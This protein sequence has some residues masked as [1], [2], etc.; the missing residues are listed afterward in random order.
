MFRVVD[1]TA[2]A[3]REALV[4]QWRAIATA[5]P[6]LDLAA[7]SRIKGWRNREVVAHLALQPALL[8]RFLESASTDVP[9]LSL[10]ANLAG[11]VR[12]AELIDA[13]ARDASDAD[14]DFGGRL[15]RALPIL[16]GADLAVT[17]TTLQ[18]RIAL[19][20]YLRTRCIEAVVHGCDLNP[21]VTPDPE[22]LQVAADALL[23]ALRARR[24]G[25]VP[26]ARTLP[27]L[28]WVDQATGRA[29]ASERLDGVLPVMS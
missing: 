26:A 18:G 25:L 20:D 8:A 27:L 10:T 3:V 16:S 19:V 12:L 28:E 13:S 1:G 22:A 24:P 21:P 5:L 14:L 29:K 6:A 11:T 23:D 17:V 15:E 9:E 4:R 2:A 7:S